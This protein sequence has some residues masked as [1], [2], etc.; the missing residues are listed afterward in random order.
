MMSE[1]D[2][3]DDDVLVVP[4]KKAY[5]GPATNL[6]CCGGCCDMRRATIILSIV[7]LSLGCINLAILWGAEELKY[8]T[9]EEFQDIDDDA[10][11]EILNRS[12]VHE[13]IFLGIGIFSN[14]CSI[15]GAIRYNTRLVGINIAWSKFTPATCIQNSRFCASLT[16]ENELLLG[17]FR[18]F[19]RIHAF[20]FYLCSGHILLCKYN[21]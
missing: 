17:L 15:L 3:V 21:Y 5:G 2:H 9:E 6:I 13:S 8:E 14:L 16:L 4:L 11:W 19:T 12:Y 18:S 7:F 1:D 20:V 10:L